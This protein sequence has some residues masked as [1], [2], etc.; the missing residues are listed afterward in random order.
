M[1]TCPNCKRQNDEH[2]KICVFCG[3][4]FAITEVSTRAL[5][6]TDYEE[7]RPHWGLARFDS[8]MRLEIA[9]RGSL[10]SYHFYFDEITEL[11]IGRVDP[12]TGA[13]PE[14]DLEDYG[15]AEK[16]VSRRHAAIVRHDT[17]LHVV[18][19]NA[20]NGTFL[21]G[22]RLVPNQPRILRDGDELRLGHLVLQI[23]FVRG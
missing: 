14:I 19:L 10:D 7:G 20:S 1:I 2:V 13:V 12:E 16:G 11:L 4:P 3:E 23:T 9:I 21:N 6:D 5:D 8:R 18:D 22:Q 17:S 15:A